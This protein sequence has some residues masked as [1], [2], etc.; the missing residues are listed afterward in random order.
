[1]VD[2]E[3]KSAEQAINI[4][5]EILTYN[6]ENAELISA[7]ENALNG[8]NK[9]W[10]STGRDKESYVVELKKQI[11][12]LNIVHSET[13]RLGRTIISYAEQAKATSQQRV[14]G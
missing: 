5:N 8:I 14:N 12:N 2:I 1:M 6:K 11:G 3:L 9:Y 13:E 10:E 4:C 7:L